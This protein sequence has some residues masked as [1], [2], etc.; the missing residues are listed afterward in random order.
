MYARNW[1]AGIRRLRPIWMDGISPV[2]TS[3][4]AFD[5]DIWSIRHTCGTVNNT[6]TSLMDF[7]LD[8]MVPSTDGLVRAKSASPF[9]THL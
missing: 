3:S 2:D 4:Y 5:L 6:G 9:R 7:H 1:A 8:A